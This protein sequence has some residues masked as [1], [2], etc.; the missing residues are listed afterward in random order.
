MISLICI[1]KRVAQRIDPCGTPAFTARSEEQP[2][3]ITL[4]ERSFKKSDVYLQRSPKSVVTATFLGHS[5]AKR[6][7]SGSQ[8]LGTL[9]R[10]QNGAGEHC[11][12]EEMNSSSR[13]D[14]VV[15]HLELGKD[16]YHAVVSSDFEE[17]FRPTALSISGASP[18]TC[19]PPTWPLDINVEPPTQNHHR[20]TKEMRVGVGNRTPLA[21]W[22]RG[23][24]KRS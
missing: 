12:P 19:P 21:R 14:N 10:H 2:P 20:K 13:A 18:D 8:L 17:T 16:N 4:S 1:K 3:T 7:P 6:L 9:P 11:P 23:C 5:Q 24:G 22:C 15:V